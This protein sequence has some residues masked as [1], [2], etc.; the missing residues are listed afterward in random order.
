MQCNC[1]SQER[2]L[3]ESLAASLRAGRRQERYQSER[4]WVRGN[5][6]GQQ[7]RVVHLIPR[8]SADYLWRPKSYNDTRNPSDALEQTIPMRTPPPRVPGCFSVTF[9]AMGLIGSVVFAFAMIIPIIRAKFVYVETICTVLDK[10]LAF[11]DVDTFRPEFHIEYQVAG[12]AYRAWT[13]DAIG[14]YSNLESRSD[15]LDQ[16]AVGQQYACWYD[17]AAPEKSV[18]TRD[19][20]A[21][22]F[23]ALIPLVF[24]IVGFG[25]LIRNGRRRHE[26]PPTGRAEEEILPAETI[27]LT[28]RERYG[29]PCA[30]GASAFV[31]FLLVCARACWLG[32]RRGNIAR[33]AICPRFR[34]PT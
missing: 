28:K 26:A 29:L 12:R 2:L 16:F 27:H 11:D 21:M 22:A 9:L 6:D 3:E 8:D 34:R 32:R 15:I 14:M 5:S 31:G 25:G 18:L 33:N 24:V 23:L 13:Y 19:V 20:D 4:F 7:E 30:F 10:R 17:A 1:G